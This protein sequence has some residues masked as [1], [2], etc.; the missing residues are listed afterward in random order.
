MFSAS[1]QVYSI[2]FI[3]YLIVSYTLF[4]ISLILIKKYVKKEK[5]LNWIIRGTALALLIIIIINRIA[6]AYQMLVTEAGQHPDITSWWYLI[7]E[8]FCGMSALCLSIDVAFFKKNNLALHAFAYFGLLGGLFAGTYPNYLN[9][10]DF[11]SLRAFTGLLHHSLMVYMFFLILITGYFTPTI[12]RWYVPMFTHMIFVVFG[13]FAIQVLGH[14]GDT[15]SIFEPLVLSLPILT[16]WWMIGLGVSL[17]PII[18]LI[19]YEH[20]A[21]KKHFKQ[22]FLE[23]KI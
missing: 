18:F 4:I 10:L 6:T 23:M 1:Y 17:A 14:P 11:W 13:L 19:F 3:V 21:N 9:Y 15:M 5:T 16:S 7:P 2:K 20:F 22:I 12:K 8:T